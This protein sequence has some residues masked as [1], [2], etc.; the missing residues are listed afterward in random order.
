MRH[1]TRAAHAT[2]RFSIEGPGGPAALELHRDDALDL[3]AWLGL[4]R[5][6]FGAIE[7]RTLAPLC[8]R[9][10]W[11]IPRNVDAATH[12]RAAG[13]LRAWTQEMLRVAEQTREG[14]LVFFG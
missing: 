9:R 6:E 14:S 12:T 4:E 5:P 13:T 8:R 3:L 7:A 2:M 11:P 1:K 10:L